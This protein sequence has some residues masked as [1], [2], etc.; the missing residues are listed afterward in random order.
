MSIF[1]LRLVAVDVV[2]LR[3]IGIVSDILSIVNLHN[4]S[5]RVLSFFNF[6]HHRSPWNSRS[7]TYFVRVVSVARSIVITNDFG[8]VR[9]LVSIQRSITRSLRAHAFSHHAHVTLQGNVWTINDGQLTK[10]NRDFNTLIERSQHLDQAFN[11][12][13]A[14]VGGLHGGVKFA[15]LAL[16]L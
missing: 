7:L 16:R 14:Q 8:H 6:L 15:S 2:L 13:T 10:L 9:L 1:G 5:I 3:V 4:M 12:K 11:G